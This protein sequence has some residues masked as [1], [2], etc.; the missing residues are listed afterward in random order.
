MPVVQ[1]ELGLL[2]VPRGDGE[3]EDAESAELAGCDPVQRALARGRGG[4]KRAK[5]E[6]LGAEGV[7]AEDRA[8]I[9]V[10]A[11][12]AKIE[13]LGAGALSSTEGVDAED[14]AHGGDGGP[15]EGSRGEE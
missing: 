13:V 4:A 8:K 10:L 5:I 12:R 15:G 1:M 9:E 14:R 7:D 2:R 11:N 3:A 6:V